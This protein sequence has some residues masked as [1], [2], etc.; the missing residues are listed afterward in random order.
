MDK[1][2][3]FYWSCLIGGPIDPSKY[4]GNGADWPLRQAVRDAYIK[5][6]CE[7]NEVCSSGWGINEE[8]YELLRKVNHIPT[9]DLKKLIKKYEEK[10]SNG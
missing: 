10:N 6:F 4:E 9:S 8:R 5:M 3:K 7:D 1:E 2:K